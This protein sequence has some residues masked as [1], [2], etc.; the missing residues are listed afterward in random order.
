MKSNLSKLCKALLLG[1]AF[2]VVGCTDYEED[3]R[4]VNDD[5]TSSVSSLEKTISDLE[6]KMK[7]DFALKSEVEKFKSD[8]EGQINDKIAAV[9]SSITKLDQAVKQNAADIK[10]AVADAEKAVADANAAIKNLQDT[11]ADKSEVD[12]MK[13]EI[14]N[15]ISALDAALKGIDGRVTVNEKKI[16][17]IDV[18]MTKLDA[19]VEGITKRVEI[20]EKAVEQNAKDIETLLA[21]CKA[22]KERMDKAEEGI[23]A[24]KEAIEKEIAARKLAIELLEATVDGRYEE[25]LHHVEAYNEK[26]AELEQKD[27][28][29]QDAIDDLKESIDEHQEAIEALQAED[30][31][32]AGLIE[33]L[34]ELIE[35][36]DGRVETLEGEIDRIDSEIEDIND[37]INGIDERLKNIESAVGDLADRIQSL[38]FVPEYSDNMASSAIYTLGEK[39]IVEEQ[40]VRATFKVTPTKLAAD[41]AAQKDYNVFVLGVPVKTRAAAGEDI[42]ASVVK[43]EAGEDGRL[44]VEAVFPTEDMTQFAISL[45]V[46][47]KTVVR[48]E[49]VETLDTKNYKSS[50]YVQVNVD[51]IELSDRY[52][53]YNGENIYENRDEK[54]QWSWFGKADKEV[55]DFH[56]GYYVAINLGT[57]NKP[58]YYTLEEAAELMNIDVEKITPAYKGGVLQSVNGSPEKE[59]CEA[60]S[61]IASETVQGYVAEING[62]VTPE[63]AKNFVGHKAE[64]ICDWYFLLGPGSGV[65]YNVIE[66]VDSYEIINRKY[67]INIESVKLP[68][69]YATAVLLSDDSSNPTTPNVQHL[70]ATFRTPAGARPFKELEVTMTDDEHELNIEQ[71]VKD[72][73]PT[74]KVN[75]D[76]VKFNGTVIKFDLPLLDVDPLAIIKAH[77]ASVDV[78]NYNFLQGEENVYAFENIYNHAESCTDVTVKFN[79]TLGEMPED[80]T[81]AI[82]KSDVVFTPKVKRIELTKE[83]TI[84]AMYNKVA[85]YFEDEDAFKGSLPAKAAADYEAFR[86]TK[87][88]EVAIDKGSNFLQPIKNSVLGNTTGAADKEAIIRIY[89]TAVRSFED[90]FRFKTNYESW[91]GVTYT[92]TSIVELKPTGLDLAVDNL[93]VDAENQVMLKGEVVNNVFTVAKSDL[94]NY[95]KVMNI[96]SDINATLLKIKYEVMTAEDPDNGYRGVPAPAASGV[97]VSEGGRP[98]QSLISWDNYTARDLEVKATLTYNGIYVADKT[99]TFVIE[100]PITK[101]TASEIKVQREANKTSETTLWKS[102]TIN[103][104]LDGTKNLVDN[105]AT[106]ETGVITSAIQTKYGLTLDFSD[107]FEVKTVN[108]N[109]SWDEGD[110]VTNLNIDVTDGKVTYTAPT[111]GESAATMYKD[112]LVKCKVKMTHIFD[113]NEG[114]NAK[115][116]HGEVDVLVRFSQK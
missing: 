96:N 93:Y 91:Y 100:D 18:A 27:G 35:A 38:V 32:L 84:T 49:E 14:E 69:D 58:A 115:E 81:V 36:L 54:V 43:V 79:L 116:T 20:L 66:T 86:T 42:P 1:T 30:E 110:V 57:N 97:S 25:Y 80:Q 5:L 15:K 45:Y 59:A 102:L 90:T 56:A 87:T 3:I 28:E 103:G 113:Y 109:G 78:S 67:D 48:A 9:N 77:L 19:T 46:T 34:D 53:L 50:E 29:L 68:W 94:A 104:A 82:N 55:I 101:F 89:Q 31:R 112:I 51:K 22:L 92:Y 114:K 62:E 2:A 111:G 106:D 52:V 40:T 24:N 4:K 64:M 75:G 99:I 73:N 83:E 21:D 44:N 72:V 23:G 17:E 108:K 26:V 107:D 6:A 74:Q 13:E 88:P 41:I 76:T 47:D 7:S 65:P 8:L 63:T 61:V 60:I 16:A 98:G 11:K 105:N 33:D 10:K 70:D 95:F 85:K 39:A 12:A 37:N 71:I